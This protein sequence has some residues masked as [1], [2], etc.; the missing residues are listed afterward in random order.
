MQLPGFQAN[1]FASVCC[2]LK[3]L[4]GLKQASEQWDAKLFT[5]LLTQGFISPP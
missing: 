3:S 2:L 1:S 5:A 4:Y